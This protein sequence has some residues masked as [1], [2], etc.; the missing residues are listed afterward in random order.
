MD[1]AYPCHPDPQLQG[2][3]AFSTSTKPLRIQVRNKKFRIV[4][5]IADRPEHCE[6]FAQGTEPRTYRVTDAL[7]GTPSCS[8]NRISDFS[9]TKLEIFSGMTVRKWIDFDFSLFWGQ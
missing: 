3:T 8:G 5:Y 1:G 7:F 2:T 6:H 4:G 9:D